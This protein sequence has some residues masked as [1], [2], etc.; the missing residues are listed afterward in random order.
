[1]LTDIY[2]MTSKWFYEFSLDN[3]NYLTIAI[4]CT[5]GKHR[6]V[7]LTEALARLIQDQFPFNVIIRHRQLAINTDHRSV[8][9]H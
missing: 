9:N 3:R 8:T 7:Y 4:G 1:M 5:G 2:Q 6:S